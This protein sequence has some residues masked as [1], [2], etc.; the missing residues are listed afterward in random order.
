MTGDQ[1]EIEKRAIYYSQPIE[2][3][4]IEEMLH[5]LPNIEISLSSG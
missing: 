3:T 2:D 5:G 1:R 4:L